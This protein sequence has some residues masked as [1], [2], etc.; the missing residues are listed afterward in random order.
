MGRGGAGEGP[1]PEVCRLEHG[2]FQVREPRDRPPL[3]FIDTF[4]HCVFMALL[5]DWVWGGC[6]SQSSLTL[7]GTPRGPGPLHILLWTL[8][9]WGSSLQPRG[10]GMGGVP[11]PH[12]DPPPRG[13]LGWH[14]GQGSESVARRGHGR[15]PARSG[16]LYV[17]I[18]GA[19]AEALSGSVLSHPEGQDRPSCITLSL[20]GVWILVSPS[21][22]R[23]GLSW[24]AP[25]ALVQAWG[26][27]WAWG[28]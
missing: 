19:P 27:R 21:A 13:D 17:H 24:L 26:W 8:S 1:A 15:A 20:R 6:H 22:S 4:A 5:L 18:L 25:R 12:P 14:L 7:G 9:L 10:Q 2:T 28:R 23:P 3:L 11:F 16:R